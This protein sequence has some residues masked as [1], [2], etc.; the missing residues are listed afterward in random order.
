MRRE[1]AAGRCYG[2]LAGVWTFLHAVDDVV[3]SSSFLQAF[4]EVYISAQVVEVVVEEEEVTSPQAPPSWQ[5]AERSAWD[6]FH[7]CGHSFCAE[8]VLLRTC[9][10]NCKACTWKLKHHVK[11]KL[12]I[13]WKGCLLERIF[14]GMNSHVSLEVVQGAKLLSTFWALMLFVAMLVHHV[15]LHCLRCQFHATNLAIILWIIRMDHDEMPEIC[16]MNEIAMSE[17]F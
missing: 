6:S 9:K 12:Q 7:H 16:K 17:V 14:P 5:D 3:G 8:K 4:V 15:S 1:L 11:K 2:G 13:V 10:Y